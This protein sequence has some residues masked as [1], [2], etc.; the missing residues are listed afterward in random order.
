MPKL[1][2][3]APRKTPA[4]IRIG[5]VVRAKRRQMVMSQERLAELAEVSKNYVGNVERGEHE[6][7]ILV[8]DRIAKGLGIEAW[9]IV[10][11]AGL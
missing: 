9:Q 4:A 8:L 5:K 11:E 7:S 10:K 3:K 6:P 2:R 1:V